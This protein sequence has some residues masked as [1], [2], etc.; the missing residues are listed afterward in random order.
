M[1]KLEISKGRRVQAG[2]LLDEEVE[3][4]LKEGTSREGNTI[5]EVVQ[6]AVIYYN[7]AVP[8]TKG[9]ITEAAKRLLSS[10]TAVSLNQL[11]QNIEEDYYDQ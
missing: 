1:S 10:P 9:P 2:T 8:V 4:Y 7:S 11:N 6:V 5:K 3:K